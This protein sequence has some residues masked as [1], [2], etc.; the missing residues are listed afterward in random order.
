MKKPIV[1]S[2]FC[3]VL[4]SIS[5][6]VAQASSSEKAQKEVMLESQQLRETDSTIAAPKIKNAQELISNLK[7]IANM[8]VQ[9]YQLNVRIGHVM[10]LQLPANEKLV[11]GEGGYLAIGDRDNWTVSLNRDTVLIS[12]NNLNIGTNLII[13]T[14]KQ[15]HNLKFT[16]N[17]SIVS[18]D[19]V[20]LKELDTLN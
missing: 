3:A 19:V 10:A 6:G 15:L 9:Q 18:N 8:P 2:I 5:C 7:R 4:V 17:D 1:N 20:Q 12:P 14:D 11:V 16:M 13:Q